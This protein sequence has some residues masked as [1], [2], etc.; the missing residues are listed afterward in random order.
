M[1]CPL[2]GRFVAFDAEFSHAD[3]LGGELI[4]LIGSV[5]THLLL[6]DVLVDLPG[7]DSVMDFLAKDGD[8]LRGYES[9]NVDT[10]VPDFSSS[11]ALEF[12]GQTESL[13]IYS[14]STP[15]T[16]GFMLVQ[17]NDPNGGQR[18]LKEV[19][20]S[21]GKRIKTENR[22]LTSNRTADHSMR[23]TLS[24][25]DANPT[26]S[27]RIVF[28]DPG[29]QPKPPV[30]EAIAD[31]TMVEGQI[32]SFSVAAADPDGTVPSLA[33]SPLPATAQFTDEGCGRG[34]FSWFPSIGQAGSYTIIFSAFDGTFTVTRRATIDVCS[35][36][37][38]DCDGMTDSWELLCFGSLSRDGRGDFD[39]DGATD[40]DEFWR[41]SDPTRSN[42]PGIPQ[43]V[44]PADKSQVENVSPEITV[45]NGKDPD[46][47]D[48][49]THEFEL[50]GLYGE[51]GMVTLLARGEGLPGI[52]E[53]TS[54]SVPGALRE[55]SWYFFRVRATDGRSF[56]PWA[57]GS[58][59]MNTINEAPAACHISSPRDKAEVSS[60]TPILQVTNTTDPDGDLPITVFQ[61]FSSDMSTVVAQSPDLVQGEA[62]TTSWEVN[63]RLSENT[64]YLWQ[65]V[66]TDGHGAFAASPVVSFYVN[67]AKDAPPAPVITSPEAS[68]EVTEKEVRIVI[69]NSL[70][71][72]GNPVSHLFECDIV[73]T[74]DSP[75]KIVS[76][77]VPEGLDTTAWDVSALCD[78]TEYFFRVKATDG[79]AESPWVQGS[80]FVNTAND[81][82]LPPTLRNPGD[83]A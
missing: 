22:W 33:A 56:S 27:Y 66:S 67:T 50:Y 75:W 13:Q 52:D 45:R 73:S 63:P 5:D 29:S 58:F 74:F 16:V 10:V 20:R 62:G 43:I 11:A 80:F 49:I 65:V 61:V 40:F 70:D 83:G 39:G 12:E 78:N 76:G 1:I 18:V 3:E 51:P 23:H 21:D 26:G 25:F 77:T 59:L 60:T 8:V 7:R 17:L 71:Q 38:S 36:G 64:L 55:N 34:I 19:L 37:D 69:S 79:A 53:T 28:Q 31:R 82:P 44:S 30:L 54:W 6:R 81:R 2:S 72:E 35:E 32:V 24:L 14:L 68:A 41:N 15:E 42:A 57:Y 4:S 46:P 48:I 9:Q 47:E